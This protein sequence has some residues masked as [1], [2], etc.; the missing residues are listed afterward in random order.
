[1]FLIM[2]CFGN[3]C[4]DAYREYDKS[5]YFSN[6]K[7]TVATA[8]RLFFGEGWSAIMWEFHFETNFATSLLFCLYVFL[9]TLL[10][11]QLVLGFIITVSSSVDDAP[12]QSIYDCLSRFREGLTEREYASLYKDFLTINYQMY[13]LHA[14]INEVMKGS[15]LLV[16]SHKA[17]QISIQALQYPD[18][19]PPDHQGVADP[20]TVEAQLVTTTDS[21]GVPVVGAQDVEAKVNEDCLHLF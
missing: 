19:M 21:R 5:G 8:L 2:L 4:Q 3:I 9:C 18:C 20:Q 7:A 11:F 15:P 16:C 17:T 14:K 6:L 12:T 1:M 10:L 13:D